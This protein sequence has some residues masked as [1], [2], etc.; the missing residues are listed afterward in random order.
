MS[1]AL[2]FNAQLGIHPDVDAL[3]K[4]YEQLV[5]K[6]RQQGLDLVS[7]YTAPLQLNLAPQQIS[8]LEPMYD[9]KAV[10]LPGGGSEDFAFY[11]CRVTP[12]GG[13]AAFCFMLCR[14]DKSKMHQ[15]VDLFSPALFGIEQGL[16]V[17]VEIDSKRV[18]A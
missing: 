2:K 5:E 16:T 11:P 15:K 6:F 17:D 3:E 8:F 4:E 10:D 14:G 7:F 18:K 12:T 9:F 13:A 1:D